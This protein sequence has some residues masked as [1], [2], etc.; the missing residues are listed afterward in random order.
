MEWQRLREKAF[1]TTKEALAA[2]VNDNHLIIQAVA[3]ME[4][5]DR[6]SNTLIKRLREWYSLY[7]PEFSHAVTDNEAFTRRVLEKSKQE[8]LQELQCKQS[9]GADLQEQDVQE[10]LALAGMIRA[11]HEERARLERYLETIM[12]RHCPNITAIAGPTIAAR[13][14]QEAGSLRQLA[15]IQASTIQ[16]YGAEKALFRHLKTG[17]KPPKHGHIINHPLI[18]KAQAKDKGKIARA[19]ADKLSIAAKVDYFKGD[20]IGDELRKA[21]EERFG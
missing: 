5:L 16:M 19:L 10:M 12:Q 14:L 9:M 6:T 18:A 20:P 17:A 8:Q 21:L 15:I 4:D 7:G 11:M 2:S 3:S 1:T 13:L